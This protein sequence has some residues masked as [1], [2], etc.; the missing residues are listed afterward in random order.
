MKLERLAVQN[1]TSYKNRTEFRFEAGIN[2]LIG[3]NGGGKTN[4]QRLIALTLTKYFI[5]QYQ[6]KRNDQEVAIEL[7]DPW[8]QRIIARAFPKY[9]G[10]DDLEQIIEI[11][12]APEPTDVAN[13]R[14]IG[15]HLGELNR[16]LSY[17]EKKYDSY[18][19]LAFVDSIESATSFTFVVRNLQLE[20]PEHGT[21][22]WAFLE[23]L[24]TFF[25]FLRVASHVPEMSLSAPVFFFSSDR[26]LSRS[27][28]IQAGQLT[29]QAY[30]DGFRSAYHAA[31][32]DSM[33]LMQWGAQHFARLHRS[34]VIEASTSPLVWSDF[35]AKYP[36]VQLLTRYMTQLGYEWSFIHDREQLS[37][38][39]ILIK[40][41]AQLTP[42]MFSS[43]ERE[44]VHFLLAMFALNVHG[45]LVLVDEPELHLHP[46]WQSIFLG[47]FRDLAPERNCQFIIT[48]HSPVFV[49]PD[50]VNSITRI[51]RSPSAGSDRI[52]LKD[53]QLPEKKSLVRM[54]NS[55]NNERLFFADKVVLVEGITDRL[56]ISAL[57]QSSAQLFRRNEAVEVVEVGG[58]GNFAD[59]RSVL[60]GLLTPAFTIADRDYLS[61]VGSAAVR[62]LFVADANGLRDIL[63]KD[64][65]SLDRA[66]LVDRLG[67]AIRDGELDDLKAFWE[68]LGTRATKFKTS[69]SDIE[70]AAFEAEILRLASD[71]IFVFREGDIEA[72]LPGSPPDLKGVVDLLADRQWINRIPDPLRRLELAR[73]ACAILQPTTEQCDAFIAAARAGAVAFP[74]T[75][76]ARSSAGEVRVV[77]RGDPE[78]IP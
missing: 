67:S 1:V 50:T 11:E 21:P 49:T 57:L 56:V 63:T 69:P 7:H 24:R 62:Q 8:N 26:A 6:F 12:L 68:Y 66:T 55:Q 70:K 38:V 46:R 64:K 14:S 75:E 44:I 20:A 78:A 30:F 61:D 45:G 39:F 59:Y 10:E 36:D 74:E 71:N 22:A 34:A 4:L 54:I 2:I 58:K 29:D 52:A 18:E 42:D 65:R 72:Y 43:G 47:L 76:A 25:I 9:A 60:A 19:P 48:T 40:D 41:G 13:I 3:T 28:E 53:V 32:G 27:F 17:W 35:F 23:Y 37:Y 15:A 16:E 77:T 33:N 31:T 5:H 73:I 51:F